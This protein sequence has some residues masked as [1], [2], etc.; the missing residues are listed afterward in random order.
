MTANVANSDITLPHFVVQHALENPTQLALTFLSD[1]DHGCLSYVDLVTRASAIASELKRRD[2]AGHPI[3]LLYPAGPEYLCALLGCFW[4]GAIAVPA[5]PPSMRSLSRASERVAALVANAGAACALTNKACE[6]LLSTTPE[7]ARLTTLVT[8]GWHGPP[9][10]FAEAPL[11]AAD[12]EPIDVDPNQPCLLQY[13][14]GS[15]SEPKGVLLTHAQVCANLSIIYAASGPRIDGPVVT[16]LPPYHDMG[17]IGTLLFALQR[18]NHIIQLAPEAFVRRPIRWLQAISEYRATA[19]AA[20]NFALELCLRRI[21]PAQRVGLDLS[22]LQCLVNGSE[23]IDAASLEA[24][25]AAFAPYGLRREA[26]TPSY[27]MAEATLMLSST[28]GRTTPSIRAYAAAGLERG[29]A[30]APRDGERVRRLVG[31]GV[32]QPAGALRIVDPQ[33]CVELGPGEIGEIWARSPS[34]ASGYW[35]R[36]EETRATFHA[37]LADSG[38]GPFLRTGDLGFLDDGELF[39][40]GRIKDSIIV[41]GKKH[42]PQD[43]ERTVQRIDAALSADAGAAFSI[44]LEHSEQLCVVQEI[45]RRLPAD[46]AVLLEKISHAILEHHQLA[47]HAITL[48]KRGT[49]QKTSSGKIKRRA[50]R[51]AFLTGGL[52]V[53]AHWQATM[54][55]LMAAAAAYQTLTP[56][57]EPE[58]PVR[59]TRTRLV[60]G[61]RRCQA[62]ERF[63]RERVAQF[64]KLSAEALDIDVPLAQYGLDSLAASELA[65]ALEAWLGEPVPTTISYDHPTIR[66]IAHA[67]A[68]LPAAV[69]SSAESSVAAHQPN[70]AALAIVGMACRFP[71]AENLNEFWTLLQSGT[72]AVGE[73]PKTRWDAASL[74]AGNASRAD[75]TQDRFGG[76]LRGIE[77]FDAEFFGISPREAAR[78]DPQQRLFLELAWQA[79]EDAGIAPESLAGSDTGVFA[80]VC[81]SDHALVHG[82]DLNRVDADFGTGHSASVVANRVSYFLDLRGPSVSFDNACASSLVALQAACQSLANGEIQLAIVG[83]VNAV[84]A[85]HAGLFFASARALANDG[86]CKTFDKRADGF[87]R[88]EGCGVIVLQALPCA[89]AQRSRVYALVAGSAIA[90]SGASNG[91]M[92][93]SGPAQERVIRRALSRAGLT[94][95]ALDYIEAHGVGSKLA[96]TVELRA[97]GSLLSSATRKA[98]CWVGSV[99]T[100][101]GHLEAASG[102]ASVIKTALALAHEEIP[103]HLHVTELHSEIAE[104]ALPIAVPTQSVAWRRSERP[105]HAGVSTFGF[106]GSNAHVILS[107]AP[108]RAPSAS[109]AQAVRPSHVLALSARSA[110]ALAELALSWADALPA[111]TLAD[112]CFSANVGRKHFAQRA[113]FVASNTSELCAELRRFAGEPT[114]AARTPTRSRPQQLA[115]VFGEH[116]SPPGAGRAL[117]A[118]EPEF[119]RAFDQACAWLEPELGAALALRWFGPETRAHDGSGALGALARGFTL[120][121]QYALWTQLRVW[122]V[123]PDI[124][125][126]W[127]AGEYPAACAAGVL[128]WSDGLRLAVQRAQLM[129]SLVPGAEIVRSLHGFRRSL[130]R[131]PL[132]AARRTLLLASRAEPLPRA[133][134]LEPEHFSRHVYHVGGPSSVESADA[135]IVLGDAQRVVRGEFDGQASSTLHS[136]ECATLYALIAGLYERGVDIDWSAFERPFVRERLS[137]PGYPF[138]RKRCWLEAPRSAALPQAFSQP[139]AAGSVHPLLRR[140]TAGPATP[141]LP[142]SPDSARSPLK[143]ADA[144]WTA[145]EPTKNTG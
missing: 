70:G 50:M 136:D 107:E 42:F 143:P 52:S 24:F 58:P 56:A 84:L 116:V 4:A 47:V 115:V 130:A 103:R 36:P 131:T 60:T 20:P 93:P 111:L 105:R 92:A 44:E 121:L 85:P 6:A 76:F 142:V 104:R 126:G 59:E 139:A 132:T 145:S 34:V 117:Y 62:I 63:L 30:E 38:E 18:G 114:L 64:A 97:L 118:A 89:R 133:G 108:A 8:D 120:A 110:K 45:D 7:L 3:V 43:I 55:Q 134:F 13:T 98:P 88:S 87:V 109:T 23:P 10:E 122:G 124:I 75:Q 67:L 40:S 90:H 17:L 28:G 119:R 39:V 100:N 12:W 125:S 5:Y 96:D 127:G 26:L 95:D 15:T 49:V 82:A 65:E 68:G 112:A 53:V 54:P 83:G 51:E 128:A 1:G 129:A 61:E 81:G 138:Q 69:S 106:G 91:L 86:R 137:V 123:E 72:D 66:G 101:L 48:V 31:C 11:S 80:A 16:W 14:S 77:D 57:P 9:P 33:R 25:A 94:P 19:T 140:M 141:A 74:H 99:K 32:A 71:G 144:E 46:P 78:M 21:P 27:G 102:M 2:L 113:A 73:V 35:R 22:S 29:Q 135:R 37:H 41:R 79:L